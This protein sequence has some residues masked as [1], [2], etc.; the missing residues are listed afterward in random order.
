[1]GGQA[2]YIL[3]RG[4]T[5]QIGTEVEPFLQ[6]ATITLFGQPQSIELPIFGSKVLACYACVLDMHGTPRVS[7]TELAATA[8]PGDSQIQLIDPVDWSPGDKV[9]IATTDFESPLSSHSEVATIDAVL[10]GGRLLRLRDVTCCSTY[11]DSGAAASCATSTS[12]SWP[13]LGEIRRFAGRDVAFRAEVGLLSRNV[14]VQG[15]PDAVLCPEPSLAD[16]GVTLLSCNQHAAQIFLHSPGPDSLVGRLSNVEVRNA[17]QA[18]RLGRYAIHWHMI[19][20]IRASYQRNCSIHHS[21][22]RG[23]AVHGVN[24]LRAEFNLLYQVMG[25]AFFIEDGVEQYNYVRGNVGIRIVPSMNLL[26][27]DQVY[28]ICSC[29]ID[30]LPPCVGAFHFF[31]FLKCVQFDGKDTD[32]LNGVPS[33]TCSFLGDECK[34]LYYQQSCRGIFAVW[35]LV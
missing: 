21:W 18:F 22:N 30:L 14:I 23:A 1:M 25:H 19:G 32:V 35:Y 11:T 9:V 8:M 3:V 31:F 4:G 34:Q 28:M 10:S 5:L 24:Y 16:D 12:L 29:A 13:H 2:S 15:D 6:R 27:T 20:D 26:N 7:W 17:G 33:D